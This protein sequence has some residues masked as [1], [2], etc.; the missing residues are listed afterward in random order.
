MTK[1]KEDATPKR[2]W[3]ALA[4]LLV[5]VIILVPYAILNGGTLAPIAR[6]AVIILLAAFCA[7]LFI[8]GTT[9]VASGRLLSIQFRIVGGGATFVIF[10]VLFV[11]VV[12][13]STTQVV[14]LYLMHQDRM[15]EKDFSTTIRVPGM[16]TIAKR[17][18]R[19]EA[20]VELPVHVSEI[21]GLSIVCTG[22]RLRTTRPFRIVDGTLHLVM[23][24]AET[25]PPL[26]PEDFPSP[27]AIP[28]LPPKETVLNHEPAIGDPVQVTL[29]YRNVTEQ[30]LRLL[31][32]DCWRWYRAVDSGT[33]VSPWIDIPFEAGEEYVPYNSFRQ[34]TGWFA[35][36]VRD[37]EGRSQY[38]GCWRLFEKPVTQL[39][40]EGSPSSLR[41][42]LE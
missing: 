33:T 32:F 22:Y 1:S 39:T 27:S 30:N 42:V 14:R 11:Y 29:K 40:V 20:S 8:A 25:P 23:V 2:P 34:G 31:V 16:E 9:A 35:F 7:M 3:P 36:F 5:L 38:L 10:Y 12:P 26:R 37:A 28:D 4:V 6:Q 19:G 13:A 15:L 21:D 18:E 17:G 41:A 24:K